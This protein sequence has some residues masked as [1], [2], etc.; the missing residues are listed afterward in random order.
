MIVLF[1]G[2]DNYV[3]SELN[4]SN[5]LAKLLM[6]FALNKRAKGYKAIINHDVEKRVMS[7]HLD[8]VASS[9][10]FATVSS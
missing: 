1:G 7:Y 4:K 2:L 3:D 8:Q 5:L 10:T 6:S 9:A